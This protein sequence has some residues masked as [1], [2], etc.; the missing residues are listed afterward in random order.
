[1][2]TSIYR[3][4]KDW[5]VGGDLDDSVVL[6]PGMILFALSQTDYGSAWLHTAVDKEPYVSVTAD[7]NGDYPFYTVPLRILERVR[8]S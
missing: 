6:R 8:A 3:V 2:P 5:N 1:M 4:I 7:E